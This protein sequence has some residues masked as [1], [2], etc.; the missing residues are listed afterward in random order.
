MT[1]KFSVG[2][3][4]EATGGELRLGSGAPK[5]GGGID[6]EAPLTG[7]STDTRTIRAGEAFFALAGENHDAHDYLGEA[8]GGG[9]ALLVVSDADKAPA[10]YGGAVLVV[11]DTLRAYQDLA[12]YYRR[13]MN[14]FVVAI[15]G[16]VGKTTLKDMVYCILSGRGRVCRTEG[17][18]NNQIG[19]PR[20]I[21][22]APKDT[23][24]LVLEM[25]MAGAGEIER[26]VE[27]A[28][29]D[30]CAITNIGLAHR[31]NFDSDDGILKAKFE[32][33]SCLGEGGA[34]VIETSGS[35]ELLGLAEKGGREKGY[36]VIRVAERGA[37]ASAGADYIVSQARVSRVN[38]SESFFTIEDERIGKKVPFDIPLPG[39]YAG[40]S[41][42]FAAALCSRVGVSL[43]E[44]AEA[45]TRLERT[46]HRLEPIRIGGILVIDDTYNANPVSA[47]A[48]LEYIMNI[49]A[50]RRIAALAD[51]N[52]LG[53]GSED[54]HRQV[55]ATA[56][57][58]GIDILYTFG[59]K[60]GWIA[61][62]AEAAA[63]AMG[64]TGAYGAIKI[65]R[66]SP[67]EKPELIARLREDLKEGDVVYVKGSRTMKMEEIVH[68]L[69]KDK[70]E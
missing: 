33:T 35:A 29:P 60:A 7:I 52:E 70:D 21:L 25:G 23:E 18:L 8:A 10:D 13:L 15:T 66:Y 41:A 5:A 36:D 48:G 11:R 17:N 31:E 22:S 46:P 45:L 69:T 39:N 26:L 3:I 28:R 53:S 56:Y 68:A 4:A 47:K 34:L 67:E 44:A 27:I 24:I 12:A 32:I 19:L 50:S 62:G 59:E 30:A 54:L 6:R 42:A 14:P 20:T 37:R 63:R 38:I 16:S 40:L 55:G 9:A 61:D 51:M 57:R 65:L 43:A 58:A 49:P 64:T 2:E 1:A